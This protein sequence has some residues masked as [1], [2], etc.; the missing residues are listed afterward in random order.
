LLALQALRFWLW[1]SRIWLGVAK[2]ELQ[3]KVPER[4]SMPLLPVELPYKLDSPPTHHKTTSL[5]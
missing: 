4:T 3:D 1:F 5:H 2:R